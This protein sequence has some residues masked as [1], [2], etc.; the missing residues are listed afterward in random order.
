[1]TDPERAPD[2][3]QDGTGG[4]IAWAGEQDG[5]V[6]NW[7]RRA[8][9]RE[10][11]RLRNDGRAGLLWS[12][13]IT[14]AATASYIVG[15]LIFPG[16]QPLLA[17]LTA[18]LVVQV[19]PVTLLTSGLDRVVAVVAGV[20]LAIGFAAVV[21]LEWWSLGIL[22]FVSITIGQVLHLRSNLIE[23][24]ISGMLVLGVGSLAAEAAA[25]QRIAETLVGA[26]VGIAANL[27]FPPKVPSANAGRA[28]DGLAD[29]LSAL[30]NRAADEI[31]EWVPEGHDIAP[32]TRAWM[33]DARRITHDIP[34]VGAALLRAEQSRRLNVRAVG[35]SDLGPGL[36]QG[37]EALE[38]AAVAIRSMFRAVMDAV[39]AAPW[40]EEESAQDV[41]LGLAQTFRELAAGVDAFGQLVR[42]ESEPSSRLTTADAQ[43]LR[44]ALEG[45]HEARARLE[46]ALMSGGPPALV[47]L[48]ASVLSTVK[49]L[50]REMD[51]DE[52]V[53]RQ[54]RLTRTRPRLPHRGRAVVPGPAATG[55]E[56]TPE[57]ETQVIPVV[58][59]GRRGKPRP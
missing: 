56:T 53:R 5:A 16:T 44:D 31:D 45:L 27:L 7:W 1:V 10:L 4:P 55:S 57:E 15:L 8:L 14:V 48:H 9:S 59:P 58:P 49:R 37:L 30:L 19:T 29:S 26:A 28:I 21:P 3:T 50:L 54:V 38:H 13:R 25:G 43:S 41:L 51:L 32:A 2:G 22:I 35:T 20:A 6:R 18:M 52:R 40:R 42:D 46:E 34:R 11:A 36:R 33:G 39:S 24:A 12:L 23:V 17:P 47:E